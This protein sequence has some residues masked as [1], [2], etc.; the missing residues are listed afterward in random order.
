MT[1]KK[2]LLLAPSLILAT[3]SPTIATETL[4]VRSV[5]T[6]PTVWAVI[7]RQLRT[8]SSG[9]IALPMIMPTKSTLVLDS[10]AKGQPLTVRAGVCLLTTNRIWRQENA[11]QTACY[12]QRARSVLFVGRVTWT[13]CIGEKRSR[14]QRAVQLSGLRSLLWP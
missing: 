2:G 12:A 8:R 6:T 9:W 13:T 7:T 10:L 3:T 14:V 11:M 1:V 4:R 5:P